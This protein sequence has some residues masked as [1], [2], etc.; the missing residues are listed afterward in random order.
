MPPP[1]KPPLLLS[2]AETHQLQRLQ[3]SGRVEHRLLVRARIVCEAA[4]GGSRAEI[5]RRAGVSE[6][7]ASKW[8]ARYQSARLESPA[9]AVSDW[10]ADADRTGRPLDLDELFW[11]DVLALVT[12]DPSAHGLPITHWS[13]RELSRELVHQGRVESVHFTTIA[14]FLREHRLQ[15]HRTQQWVNRKPDPEFEKRAA[16][17]KQL[18]REASEKPSSETAII[19]FD[20]KTAIQAKERVAP[21]KPMRSGSPVKQEFEYKRHGTLC[22]FA[23]MIVQTGVIT[24]NLLPHRTNSDT[25]FMFELIFQSLF[26]QGYQKIEVIADQLNTHWS[27]ELVEVVARLCKVAE[28]HPEK[29]RTGKQRKAWL[30]AANKAIVF[31]YTPKHASW[32]NPIEAWFSILCAKL[33]RRASCVSIEELHQRVRHFITYYNERLAHPFTFK[34][35]KKNA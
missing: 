5:A 34:F 11:I 9:K 22:L 32:L 12:S 26:E 30:G 19:S 21:D 24:G 28:P 1:P 13:S 3:R 27:K 6:K 7:T 31:H 4:Q 33:L 20:E 14:T 35:W 2:A 25:S 17:V 10:L 23:A 15:P 18:L 16:E 29:M 8:I